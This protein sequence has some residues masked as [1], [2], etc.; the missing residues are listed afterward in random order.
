MI[1]TIKHCFNW[2]WNVEGAI[3]RR[4]L[5]FLPYGTSA[6]KRNYL[7]SAALA[8]QG[9]TYTHTHTHTPSLVVSAWLPKTIRVITYRF[10]S[11]IALNGSMQNLGLQEM[12]RNFSLQATNDK[13]MLLPQNQSSHRP[14]WGVPQGGEWCQPFLHDGTG[15]QRIR[16]FISLGSIV[17]KLAVCGST[18]ITNTRIHLTQSLW[19]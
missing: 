10:L 14:S 16:Q 18:A 11:V 1:N 3:K 19:S 15:S 2:N 12:L 5:V 13:L 8:R 17:V 9:T 6:C 4:G 7:Y